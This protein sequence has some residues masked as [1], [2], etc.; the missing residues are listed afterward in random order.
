MKML[1]FEAGQRSYAGNAHLEHRS[2]AAI[3]REYDDLRVR[4]ITL[5]AEEVQ[6]LDEINFVKARLAELRKAVHGIPG[7][8]DE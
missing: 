6:D 5:S 2:D 1:D 8:E 7:M 4:L 3:A